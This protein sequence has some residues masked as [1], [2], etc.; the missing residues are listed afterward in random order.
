M[1]SFAIYLQEAPEDE[2]VLASMHWGLVPSWFKGSSPKQM[3]Y[4]TSNCRSENILAKKSYKVHTHKIIYK[5]FQASARQLRL[6]SCFIVSLKD[7]MVKG[8]RCVILADGFYEWQ[9]Q[10]KVKQPFFIYFPQAEG[11]SQNKADEPAVA[12]GNKESS[13]STARTT[14]GVCLAFP[15]ALQ[16][17]LTPP[18]ISS[19]DQEKAAVAEIATSVKQLRGTVL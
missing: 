3:Q 12:L 10:D 5:S 2:Q 19:S 15:A 8:Q 6:T 1:L 13:G 18:F 7:P 4:S 16:A 14:S 11:P 17:S 9:K